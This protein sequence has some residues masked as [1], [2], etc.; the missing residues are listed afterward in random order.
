MQIFLFLFKLIS[1]WFYSFRDLFFHYWNNILIFQFAWF[2]GFHFYRIRLYIFWNWLWNFLQ[3]IFYRILCVF[4]SHYIMVFMSSMNYSFWAN[5][6]VFSLNSNIIKL[7]L[8]MFF[9]IILFYIILFYL[10]FFFYLNLA[11]SWSW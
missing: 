5:Q 3:F 4:N 9:A 8:R 11:P 2:L 10:L 1:N 7:L 6:L